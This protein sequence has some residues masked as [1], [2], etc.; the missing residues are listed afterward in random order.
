M[1][2]RLNGIA[3]YLQNQRQQ[4]SPL[5]A[6]MMSRTLGKY[7]TPQVKSGSYY[8]DAGMYG[9]PATL[10][11]NSSPPDPP[12]LPGANLPNNAFAPNPVLP[13]PSAPW[14]TRLDPNMGYIAPSLEV[15][16]GGSNSSQP[17]PNYSS[18][19]TFGPGGELRGGTGGGQGSTY[20]TDPNT[21]QSIY[22]V[23]GSPRPG[24]F[25]SKTGKFVEGLGSTALNMFVPGAGSAARAIFDAIRRHQ[26]GS[27]TGTDLS[28]NT[29][30]G[31]GIVGGAGGQSGP[32][33]FQPGYQPP[34]GIQEA[35]ARGDYTNAYGSTPSS[36]TANRIM[37]S[38]A[39]GG[40][41]NNVRG[42]TDEGH[43]NFNLG[44]NAMLGHMND[45]TLEHVASTFD[46]SGLSRAPQAGL[47]ADLLARLSGRYSQPIYVP[48]RPTA[49]P[50]MIQPARGG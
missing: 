3:D 6:A 19:I 45:G 34:S 2:I 35:I 9:G 22:N 13:G 32:A 18:G 43:N 5:D 42:T 46:P 41:P 49:P 33:W 47:N 40:Q 16:G 48:P 14:T 11:S 8:G 20:G 31:G 29:G 4:P 44:N 1:A 17:P 21:G 26:T 10:P 15:S 28:G 23:S 39:Y 12:I 37:S 27:N 50:M 38:Q 30:P 36:I 7:G 24:F 25:D